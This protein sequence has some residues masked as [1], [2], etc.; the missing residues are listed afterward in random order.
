MIRTYIIDIT[1][2]GTAGS[3]TGSGTTSRPVNGHLEA[4]KIDFTSQA[5]TA[6]T[7]IVDGMGQPILTLTN[8]NTDGWYYPH[9][10]VHGTDGAQLN[11]HTGPMAIDSYITASVAQSNAGSVQI[12]LLVSE[13]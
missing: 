11:K 9:P 8:V 5:G 13:T 6:D 3:A 7:T 1:T 10:D 2:T 12:T 4:V